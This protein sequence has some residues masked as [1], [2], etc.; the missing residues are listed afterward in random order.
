MIFSR[1]SRSASVAH[2]GGR[3]L[4][5]CEHGGIGSHTYLADPDGNV[6]E[7]HYDR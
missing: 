2:F 4:T 5:R 7:I 1:C 6:V 3:L